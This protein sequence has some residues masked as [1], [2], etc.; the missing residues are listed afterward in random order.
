MTGASGEHINLRKVSHYP[1]VSSFDV[2]VT[3]RKLSCSAALAC[4]L[5][6]SIYKLIRLDSVFEEYKAQTDYL[7]CSSTSVEYRHRVSLLL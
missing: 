1:D 6:R 4:L 7:Q 3:L 5:A 2:V